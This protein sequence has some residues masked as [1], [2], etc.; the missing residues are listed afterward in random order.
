VVE[1]FVLPT[2]GIDG[3]FIR[4]KAPFGQLKARISGCG[5]ARPEV[6]MTM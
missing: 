2:Q 3:G 1:H 4:G 5:K 6:S